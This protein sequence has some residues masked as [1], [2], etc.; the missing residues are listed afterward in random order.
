MLSIFEYQK[1]EEYLKDSWAEKKK[2]NS[3]FTIR[4]WANQM[5]IKYH[6][7]LHEMIMG[8]R[9]I[10]K[11]S[12]PLLIKSLALNTTEGLYFELMVDYS[13]SKTAE[14]KDIYVERMK[15]ISPKK[16]VKFTE[17]ESFRMLQDPIHFFI[18]ELALQ[19]DFKADALWIQTRLGYKVTLVQINE[20]IDRLLSL[21][22]LREDAQGKLHRVDQFIQS[23]SDIHDRALKEYHKNI[24]NLAMDAIDNQDVQE[25]EYQG[26]AMCIDSS[27]IPEAKTMI[28]D[29]V[30]QF[31]KEFDIPKSPNEELYQ[32]NLQLFGITKNINKGT[33][34]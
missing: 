6:N 2:K 26:M 18:A 33:K 24:M 17:L 12:I 25:R 32:M 21:D 1:P 14:E 34:K 11:S 8:K 7:S 19:K 15:S 31:T 27:R 3:S 5:N 9:K 30:A 10:P 16:V 23:K 4:A 13:R 22:I 20:A 29:F 28:R